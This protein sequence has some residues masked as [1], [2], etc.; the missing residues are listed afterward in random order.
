G[1]VTNI[2]Q[3]RVIVDYN[4]PL[5][6]QTL[7][8]NIEVIDKIEEFNDKIEFFLISKG[9]PKENVLDFKINYIK[10]NKLIEFTVPKQF[11]FQNIVFF[12][13]GLAMDLQTHMAEE[14]NDVKF[15]EIYEKINIPTSKSESVMKK[16]EE[17]NQ[18]QEIQKEAEQKE[19]TK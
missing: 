8:Y 9:I 19:N 7:D 15:I 16:V 13:F 18:E 6:G 10:E 4:H 3:G 5:A 1:V 14:I 2:V 12:K 17:F 11:L